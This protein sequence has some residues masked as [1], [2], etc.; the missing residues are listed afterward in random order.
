MAKIENETQKKLDK[1]S[2]VM[3]LDNKES[4]EKETTKGKP[5]K[6]KQESKLAF[7]T[8]EVVV[9]L[10]ITTIISLFLGSI[11]T[12]KFSK[13][14]GTKL[15]SNLQEFIS[16]YEYIVSNY[17]GKINEEEL[18]DAA[19]EAVLNKLDK[20]STYID[21]EENSNFDKALEGSYTGFGIQ[22]ASDENNNIVVYSVFKNSPA[23]DAGIKEGDIITKYNGI[24]INGLRPSELTKKIA[25]DNN[26]T[27]KLTYK[28]NNEEITVKL[29]KSTIE[30][31]S[32]SSNTYKENDKKIGYIYVSIFANNTAEQFSKELTKLE[33]KDIDSLII[34]LRSNTGGYLQ[35][36][37]TMTSEFLDTS[38]PIY[39]IQKN[40]KTSKYYSRGKTTKKYKIIVLVNESSASA[41]EVMTSALQEQYGATVIGTKTYGKGTVQEL[42]K[43]S[44]GNEYKVTT[45]NWLTSKGKWIDGTGIEPDIKVE[46]N[47]AYSDNPS[48]EN[49]NQLKKAIQ[50]ASK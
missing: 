36:A 15:N 26:K 32:V 25:N 10:V 49:D 8:S 33:K 28:R 17:N 47:D 40:D 18:L 9:L 42:Q 19:L 22:I 35:T 50:E 7:K 41:A 44:N 2:E 3:K 45:K 16:N 48:T 27:I 20:N 30:L 1:L 6:N 29:K 12:S 34:D 46:L 23:D 24:E 13:T 31:K 21:S 5:K 39:Q 14:S 11:I 4:K 38:H 37:T 43:L